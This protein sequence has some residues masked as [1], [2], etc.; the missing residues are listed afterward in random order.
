MPEGA[1]VFGYGSLVS[2]QS[3]ARTIER[4]AALGH[5]AHLAVLSG[6]GRR[7]NYGSIHSV[8]DWTLESGRQVTGGTIVALGIVESPDEAVNGT[9]SKV[10]AVELKRLDERERNY[11]RIDVTERVAT[12]IE[13]I[14]TVVTYRPRQSSIE[15]YEAARDADTAGIRQDYWDLV[16]GAF[17]DFG[18]HHLDRYRATTPAPDVPVVQITNVRKR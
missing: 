15:R 9:I 5:D 14:G 3:L 13:G 8:G 17:A 6:F 7:W 10:T 18:P 2:P 4:T 12:S 16:E 1:W 11:D